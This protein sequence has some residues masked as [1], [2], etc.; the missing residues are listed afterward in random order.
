MRFLSKITASVAV[1]LLALLALASPASASTSSTISV[2]WITSLEPGV[3]TPTGANDVTWPQQYTKYA[4]ECDAV[5]QIDLYKY[6]TSQQKALVKALLAHGSLNKPGSANW[7][8]TAVVISWKIVVLPVCNP[9]SSSPSSPVSSTPTVTASDTPT[10]PVVQSSPP[11]VTVVQPQPTP[12]PSITVSPTPSP[13]ASP[14]VTPKPTPLATPPAKLPFTG[15]RT[16][17]LS[18]SAAVAILLGFTC[19]YLTRR[20]PHTSRR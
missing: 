12:S 16:D 6:G 10:P 1:F 11:Q 15:L 14:V 18:T 4:P 19:L 8:D 9:T 20:K 17:L 3:T 5:L 13:T 2:T 7:T